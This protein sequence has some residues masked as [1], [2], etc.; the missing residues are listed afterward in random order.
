MYYLFRYNR[1]DNHSYDYSDIRAGFT[2]D[3]NDADVPP[4]FQ[5]IILACWDNSL[6]SF[7]K[8]GIKGFNLPFLYYY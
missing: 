1:K 2:P 6:T 5:I 7:K 8:L 3:L 4:L